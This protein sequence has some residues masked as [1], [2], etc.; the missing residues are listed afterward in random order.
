[1]FLVRY[2]INKV[3]GLKYNYMLPM[4]Y[5]KR[6]FALWALLFIV[7]KISNA[8]KADSIIAVSIKLKKAADSFSVNMAP[9]KYNKSFAFSFTLDD[10]LVCDYLVAYPFF[11][12]G[13]VSGSYMDQWGNDQGGD[14]ISY[15]GLYFTDGCGNPVAFKAAI[16]INAKSM[17]GGDTVSPHGFLTW[18]QIKTLYGA[19]WDVLNHSYS[20]ATGKNV[21]A[22][23][24]I[25]K[26]NEEVER[27]LGFEMKD[28][29]IPG[30]HDDIMSNGPYTKAAFTS[31]MQTVQCE[32][33][34]NYLVMLDSTLDLHHLKLGRLFLH[35]TNR[36]LN[37][38][39]N[40]SLSEAETSVLFDTI[41]NNLKKGVFWVNA[42]THG[43]SNQNIWNISM[44]FPEFISFFNQLAANYGYPGA[45]NMW[46]APTQEVYE[47]LLNS[48]SI[49]YQIK[50]RGKTIIIL[51]NKK[52]IPKGLRYHEL[53]F[54]LNSDRHIKSVS[55]I[56]CHIESYTKSENQDIINI[57]MP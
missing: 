54:L 11:N 10:G 46:M 40:R 50:K 44:T 18:K 1:M 15:H 21:E 28:F 2:F 13:K 8:Q 48:H 41:H 23:Y 27:H 30:G 36:S 19:G 16:A 26:N 6:L 52:T 56:H 24:E 38:T 25:K 55:G 43:V 37:G 9:L 33:F 4:L 34:G 39:V 42:F 22:S 17:E 47:Y 3:S 29:V 32:D 49:K 57:K 14:G 45:D 20:H 5:I 7:A 35:T 53:T 51:I 12:G 31:G